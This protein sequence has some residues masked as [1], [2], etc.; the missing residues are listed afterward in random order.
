MNENTTPIGRNLCDATEAMVRGRFKTVTP[1]FLK[2]DERSK[3]NNLNFI[4]KK[5]EKV[6]KIKPKARR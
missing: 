1:V 3:I 6:E 4:F 2:K 5:L